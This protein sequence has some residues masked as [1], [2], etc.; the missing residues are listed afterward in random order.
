MCNLYSLT[1][2]QSIVLLS[3]P[4]RARALTDARMFVEFVL[5]TKAD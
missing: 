4:T 3:A 1:S 2:N 5:G